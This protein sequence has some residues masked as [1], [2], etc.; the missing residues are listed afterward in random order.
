MTFDAMKTWSKRIDFIQQEPKPLM[1]KN[2][3]AGFTKS[4]G[5]LWLVGIDDAGHMAP[6]DHPEI[7]LFLVE[8]FLRGS[9]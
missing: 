2:A 7:T 4:A 1:F 9:V 8:K 6:K 3:S 5:N